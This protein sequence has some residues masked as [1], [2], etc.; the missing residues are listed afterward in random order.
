MKDPSPVQT[1]RI[2]FPP[3]SAHPDILLAHSGL[4]EELAGWIRQYFLAAVAAGNRITPGEP[5]QVGW[6]LVEPRPEADGSLALWEPDFTAMP[7]VWTRGIDRTAWAFS[8]QRAVC[9]AMNTA[10]VFPSLRDGAVVSP[11]FAA[12]HD[13]FMMMREAPKGGNSGWQVKQLKDP[14]KEG[15]M[16]SL[17]EVALQTRAVLPYLALPPGTVVARTGVA[18]E[19][20]LGE[21][22]LSSKDH[23]LLASLVRV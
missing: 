22:H 18:V 21:K 17:Y 9:D 6:M 23:P 8:Q 13:T 16:L 5:V 3:A 14:A 15:T 10:P 11:G 20:E 19:I 4:P 1:A 12:I 2:V 7:I